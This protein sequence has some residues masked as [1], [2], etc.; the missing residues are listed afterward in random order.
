[1]HTNFATLTASLGSLT[2]GA[3]LLLAVPV[4]PTQV[5]YRPPMPCIATHIGVYPIATDYCS[6]IPRAIDWHEIARQLRAA[7]RD[8]ALTHTTRRTASPT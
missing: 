6:I 3:L 4:G 5:M 2:A 8:T 1:M 7:S